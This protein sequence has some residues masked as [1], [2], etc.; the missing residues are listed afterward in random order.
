MKDLHRTVL[1]LLSGLVVHFSVYSQW[2]QTNGP[3]GAVIYSILIDGT[4]IYIGVA[5]DGFGDAGVY[6][7]SDMGENWLPVNNGLHN[8]S[9]QILTRDGSFLFAGTS[10]DGIFRSPDNGETWTAINRRIDQS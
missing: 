3:E 1:L 9:V 4:D 2:E 10:A 8:K 6:R 5:F 7:S